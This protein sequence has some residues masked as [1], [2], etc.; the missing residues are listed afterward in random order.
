MIYEVKYFFFN[1]WE[2]HLRVTPVSIHT[3]GYMGL[4]SQKIQYY[5]LKPN[6]T[7]LALMGQ[8]PLHT[9]P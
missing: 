5:T 6:R 8:D 1:F 2:M 3:D 7:S 4:T 9:Q